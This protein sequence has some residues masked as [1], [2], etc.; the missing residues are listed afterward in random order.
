MNYSRL[1]YVIFTNFSYQRRKLR[2]ENKF[3]Q[4]SIHKLIL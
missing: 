2:N 4:I 3:L 1:M